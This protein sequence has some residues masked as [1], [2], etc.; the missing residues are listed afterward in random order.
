MDN[1]DVFIAVVEAGSQSAAARRLGRP[2]QS[3]NRALMALER[4]VGIELIRRT[5]RRSQ[6]TEAGIAF[7]ERIKPA[8]A[9]IAQARL[10]AA[11][12]TET[13]RGLLRISAPAA[14]GAS[15]VVPATAEYL[16]RYPGMGIDLRLFDL[17]ADL[18]G[19]EFDVSIRIRHL[20]DSSMRVR[21]LAELRVVTYAAPRYLARFGRPVHPRDLERHQCI[22]RFNHSDECETWPFRENGVLLTVEVAGAF[23]ADETATAQAAVRNGIG[24]GR[25]PYWL[26]R[27]GLA[28]GEFALVLED[29]EPPPLPIYAVVPPSRL[30]PAKTR[31]FIEI[32]A[33]RLAHEQ[34]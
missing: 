4:D 5:T 9:E 31:R 1:M 18:M 16:S 23:R 22:L 24:I 26:V 32:L 7:Y 28:Q 10:D 21:K 14:F 20:Q 11:N 2:L 30:T 33:E 6:V 15:F 19:D 3:V 34:L 25:G 27:D 13:P 29:F 12:R 8:L 17:P